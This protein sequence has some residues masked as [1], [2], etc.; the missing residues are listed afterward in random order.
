MIILERNSRWQICSRLTRPQWFPL[1]VASR[2]SW[3][4]PNW[5]T[6]TF[7]VTGFNELRPKLR[8]PDNDII[9]TV[10]YVTLIMEARY[11]TC[12]VP[13]RRI[14][15]ERWATGSLGAEF[16]WIIIQHPP[17]IIKQNWNTKL[18]AK[19]WVFTHFSAFI[20]IMCAQFSSSRWRC[21][22]RS[23][24]NP[25]QILS[26]KYFGVK[27]G[28]VL[29]YFLVIWEIKGFCLYNIVGFENILIGGGFSDKPPLSWNLGT[30]LIFIGVC[31]DPHWCRR[32]K[33]DNFYWIWP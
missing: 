29:F 20:S 32:Q 7:C 9:F 4:W 6:N 33:T 23:H 16:V 18:N 21:L 1:G 22:W 14:R 5:S 19:S 3:S 12:G 27:S 30:V 28:C 13:Q 10:M 26:V 31:Q 8:V 17:K 11:A 25:D 15:M 24:I 2:N